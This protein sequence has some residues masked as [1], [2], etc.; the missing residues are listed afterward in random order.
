MEIQ[1][2]PPGSK[3][4]TKDAVGSIIAAIDGVEK[5]RIQKCFLCSKTPQAITQKKRKQWAFVFT[6]MLQLGL[7]I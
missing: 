2:S 1:L 5:K 4:A 6:T 3:E 7:I